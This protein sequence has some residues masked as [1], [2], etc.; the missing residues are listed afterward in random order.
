MK[1]EI[2]QDGTGNYLKILGGEMDDFSERIF[3]YQDIRGFLPMEVR[4]INGEK[5]LFYP[6]SGKITLGQYLSQNNFDREDIRRF[7]QEILDMADRLEEYLLDCNGMALE[8]D[9]L[10][11]DQKSGELEGVY[12][13]GET[14]EFVRA[15]GGLLESIMEKMDH[16]NRELVFFVYGMHTL[17]K[18]AGCTREAL[19]EYVSEEK[20]APRP[21]KSRPGET[22]DQ[23]RA[24]GQDKK[25]R[26]ARCIV[27][28]GFRKIGRERRS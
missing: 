4:R 16:K 9:L 12:A 3:S 22:E 18:G 19:R 1:S 6:I 21:E 26:C 24:H 5:E 14:T 8:E 27:L 15:L 13:P 23:Q 11:V 28:L 25:I 7:V 10:F 2:W 17:T 20:K